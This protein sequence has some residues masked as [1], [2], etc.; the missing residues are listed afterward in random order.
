[1]NNNISPFRSWFEG[2]IGTD[3]NN[4]E[5][6]GIKKLELLTSITLSSGL[7]INDLNII[8]IKNETFIDKIS[9][10]DLTNIFEEDL[11]KY[12]SIHYETIR[13]ITE[14]FHKIYKYIKEYQEHCSREVGLKFIVCAYNKIQNIRNDVLD[15]YDTFILTKNKTEEEIRIIIILIN[16]LRNTENILIPLLPKTHIINIKQKEYYTITKSSYKKIFVHF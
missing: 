7:Q 4:I 6:L 16:V 12:K 1:M 5:T 8:S 2:S 11:I 3:L 13:N 14:V 9:K 10:I 15:I